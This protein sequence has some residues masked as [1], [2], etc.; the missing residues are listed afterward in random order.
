MMLTTHTLAVPQPAASRAKPGKALRWSLMVAVGLLTACATPPQQKINRYV[1]PSGV[2]VAKLAMRATLTGG[3]DLYGVYVFSDG[4]NCKD[5]QIAGAGRSVGNSPPSVNV[6]AGK[7]TTLEFITFHP[8]RQFCVVRWSFQPT[9]GRTY[10]V[11]GSGEGTMCKAALLDATDPDSIKP[12][13]TAVRRNVAGN[14]CVPL[15]VAQS[16]RAKNASGQGAAGKD[17]ANLRPGA[18]ADDLKG[19]IPQ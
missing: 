16:T 15:T 4:D 12:D 3:V 10:L 18:S 8:S 9:V 1:S 11:A 13:T 14:A 5:P 17:E 6:A 19:L 2:P 7:W